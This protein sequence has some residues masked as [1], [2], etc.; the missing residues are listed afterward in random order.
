MADAAVTFL[1]EYVQK[2]IG[3]QI[4]LISGAETE[5]KALQ[6]ELELMKAF[7]E[8][9]SKTREKGQVFIQLG[10]QVREA[11]YEAED[12]LDTCLTNKANSRLKI[13]LRSFDLAGEVKEVLRKLQPMFE[14]AMRLL[15]NLPKLER[16]AS[17]P[18]ASDDKFKK[19][20][21]HLIFI[22]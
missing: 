3:E 10:R 15:S 1:L 4:N 17:K 13:N 22:D 6:N 18:G 20:S 11:V 8:D 14:R 5:L 7:L 9:A 19:V 2:L 12:T 16:S 21:F